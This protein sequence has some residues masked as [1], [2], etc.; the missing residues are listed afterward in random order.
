[1]A[2]MLEPGNF[3]IDSMDSFNTSG[4]VMF[5]CIPCVIDAQVIFELMLNTAQRLAEMLGADVCDERHKLLTDEKLEE[6]R[7][8]LA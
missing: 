1:M 6:I 8:S 7:Y 2:N 3:D 4:L 5:M